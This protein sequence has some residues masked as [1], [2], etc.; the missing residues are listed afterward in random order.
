MKICVRGKL[1]QLGSH[2]ILECSLFISA[3]LYIWTLC[4]VLALMAFLERWMSSSSGDIEIVRKCFASLTEALVYLKEVE[5]NNDESDIGMD[6]VTEED[7]ETDSDEVLQ[8]IT[9]RT[10]VA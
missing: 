9:S 7:E 3:D 1:C 8:V 6:D 2:R 5:D 10:V 4:A